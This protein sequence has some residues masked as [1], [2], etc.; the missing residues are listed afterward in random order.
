MVPHT[1][2]RADESKLKVN[3]RLRSLRR[4]HQRQGKQ[5]GVTT[6]EDRRRQ[7]QGGSNPNATTTEKVRG[8]HYSGSQPKTNRVLGEY[9]RAGNKHARVHIERMT[10]ARRAKDHQTDA[11]RQKRES[12]AKDRAEMRTQYGIQARYFLAPPVKNAMRDE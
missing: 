12:D 4:Q 5:H 8:Q 1:T 10:K 3:E 7:T 6:S 2:A 11:K 9:L